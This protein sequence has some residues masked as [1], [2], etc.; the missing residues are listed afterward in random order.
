MQ[1]EA[2]VH[3]QFVRELGLNMLNTLTTKEHRTTAHKRR[4][5]VFDERGG[6]FGGS[7]ERVEGY[8]NLTTGVFYSRR[9]QVVGVRYRC[10]PN[11]L[12]SP[13]IGAFHTHPALYDSSVRKVRSRI[14]RMLWL[15]EM[16][17]KAFLK[18]HE[19]YGFEW[20]FVGSIDIGC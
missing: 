16:D 13:D 6:V 3:E 4:I 19:L 8:Q 12:Q 7:E 2:A 10:R 5:F 1:I 9:R 17:C 15:S 11:D 14:D 20:H 18:Q